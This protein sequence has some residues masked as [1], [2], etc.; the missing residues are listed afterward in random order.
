VIELDF[1]L[2]CHRRSIARLDAFCD[3]EQAL[4]RL[5]DL[6]RNLL[7]L[8][9]LRS[10][11]SGSCNLHFLGASD[12]QNRGRLSNVLFEENYRLVFWSL[13]ACGHSA[14]YRLA[15]AC[16]WPDPRGPQIKED[17]FIDR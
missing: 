8:E 4:G 14:G 1:S 9:G 10:K 12:A 7:R 5:D 16:A 11:W 6:G 15:A 17:A 3:S 2:Y 13:S